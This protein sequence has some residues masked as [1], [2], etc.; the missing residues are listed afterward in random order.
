M[1]LF[2]FGRGL[3]ADQTGLGLDSGQGLG[4][5]NIGAFLQALMRFAQD[6]G[7]SRQ[8]YA[9]NQGQEGMQTGTPAGSQGEAAGYGGATYPVLRRPEAV[10]GKGISSPWQNVDPWTVPMDTNQNAGGT[11]GGGGGILRLSR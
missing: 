2:S 3:S 7:R 9:Q 6:Y 10:I 1:Q 5:M 4:S 8:G 11:E